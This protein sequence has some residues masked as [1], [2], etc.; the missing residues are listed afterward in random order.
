MNPYQHL[1][2]SFDELEGREHTAECRSGGG[3]PWHATGLTLR[4][5]QML[6]RQRETEREAIADA[7]YELR[8][9]SE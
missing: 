1:F 3:I 4:R 9:S 8:T 5:E 2:D 7:E 6:R